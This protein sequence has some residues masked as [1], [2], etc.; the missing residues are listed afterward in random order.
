MKRIIVLIGLIGVMVSVGSVWAVD[1]DPF[2]GRIY[3]GF[4]VILNAE[5]FEGGV[6]ANG[7]R[8]SVLVV[9][10]P[11]QNRCFVYYS[12]G[13]LVVEYNLV[14]KILASQFGAIMDVWLATIVPAK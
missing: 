4:T 10:Y 8:N 5:S 3:G 13:Q 7:S 12:G 6:Y 9:A 14:R 2:T 1:F 11:S